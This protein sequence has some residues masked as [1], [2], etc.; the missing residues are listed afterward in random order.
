MPGRTFQF[1]YLQPPVPDDHT[2]PVY[3][4]ADPKNIV[5]FSTCKHPQQAW[6]FIKTMIDKE[7]DLQLLQLTGQMPQRKN[8]DTDNFYSNFFNEHPITKIFAKQVK[9][10]KGVDNCDVIVEVLDIIS[11]EYAACVIYGKKTPEQ[12]VRDAANAVNVLLA[13]NK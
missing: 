7:G 11:Q 2:G 6:D 12:A 9:Y 10:V 13:N 8:L 1:D 5:V 4:Y 3:T